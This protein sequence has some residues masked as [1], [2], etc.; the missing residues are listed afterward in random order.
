MCLTSIIY[1]YI[2]N[3]EFLVWPFRKLINL[4][5]TNLNSKYKCLKNNL[6]SNLYPIYIEIFLR[7][8]YEFWSDA[9][10][11]WTVGT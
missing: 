5:P 7:K 4:I 9:N 1:I 3:S 8:N 11:I 6:I 10:Y 2:H